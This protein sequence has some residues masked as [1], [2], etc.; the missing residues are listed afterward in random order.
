MKSISIGKL[1]YIYINLP[2][3]VFKRDVMPYSG[4]VT[5]HRNMH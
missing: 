5:C 4:I 3:T 2:N 1:R